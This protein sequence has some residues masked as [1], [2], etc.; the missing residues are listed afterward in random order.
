[1]NDVARI[2]AKDGALAQ[3]MG[4]RFES[5]GQQRNMALAVRDALK[6]HR[7]LVVEAGTGVGK[8]FAYLIPAILHAVENKV[9]VVVST[10]TIA[11][12]EQIMSKDIPR[13][14]RFLPEFSAVLVKGRSNYVS[15][16]RFEFAYQQRHM[17]FDMG[18]DD[19]V[20][21]EKI[22]AWLKDPDCDG[23]RAT[24]DFRPS[25]EVWENVA[26]ESDN[27][28]GPKC[29]THKTCH[30][31]AARRQVSKA[32]IL[33]VNHALFFSDLAVRNA[34]DNH[35]ILPDY[36]TVIFDEAHTIDQVAADH[37][38]FRLSN[39]SLDYQM[40]RLRGRNR[41]DKGFLANYGWNHE[42]GLVE[43]VRSEARKYFE[44]VWSL[45]SNAPA[46]PGYHKLDAPLPG[47]PVVVSA[48]DELTGS[49]TERIQQLPSE[50][51]AIE[52]KA[53]VLRTNALGV[54]LLHWHR[55]TMPIDSVYWI[56]AE[57]T[58]KA[59]AS[60]G[61]DV[62][63]MPNRFT[64]VAAPLDVG[65]EFRSRVL[66]AGVT[67]IMTSATLSVGEPPDFRFFHDR[68]HYDDEI[69]DSVR[70]D[71]PFDYPK[72]AKLVVYSAMP[73]PT[74]E[75]MEFQ[76]ESTEI[77]RDRVIANQGRSLVLFTS[78]EMLR[79][80]AARVRDALAANGIRLLVQGEGPTPAQMVAQFM[81]GGPAVIFGT[82]SFWQGVDIPGD[83]L[84]QVIVVKLPF[85]VPDHPL[86]EARLDDIRRNGGNPFFAYQ[87]PD[88]IIKLKQGFGRLIR[89]ATD[90]G[91]VH[92]L[93][94][95]VSNKPYGRQFLESLPKCRVEYVGQDK[96]SSVVRTPSRKETGSH[97][98][99]F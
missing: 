7:H 19:F 65:E 29:P 25:Q 2:F 37:F 96:P 11:L 34:N 84:T 59:R 12:Q 73:D 47:M 22:A 81:K 46:R 72:Q 28:L 87:L 51:A 60:A 44:K 20:Q 35:G 88:A 77:V 53:L 69:G 97:E 85:A 3:S 75:R 76:Q 80:T 39:T 4:N 10:H 50:E 23:S 9:R 18:D 26:S 32:Q 17:L 52:L 6:N 58:R 79:T 24:L 57:V 33:V 93:D 91:E 90:H 74:R 98:A 71:S 38:G 54:S 40:S 5:R 15:L 78:Y 48:I 83:R 8:S 67:C 63:A 55:R 21:L 14:A 61:A 49:L 82:D 89:T 64:V 41:P 86:L 95:R 42:A 30:Y 31:F 1:M 45:V 66:E 16:R 62:D 92:L 94:P 56:E 99:P 13:L 68:I 70:F 43:N 27:C 36:E